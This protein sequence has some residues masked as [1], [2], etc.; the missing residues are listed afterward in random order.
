MMMNKSHLI[1]K[2]NSRMPD[3]NK[4]DVEEGVNEILNFFSS[5]LSKN[6]RIN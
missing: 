2:I 5:E 4:E 1:S 6:N 3:L